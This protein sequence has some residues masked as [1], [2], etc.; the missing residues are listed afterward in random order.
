ME[1][2]KWSLFKLKDEI[3]NGNRI[4]FS[5]PD[6]KDILQ[7]II[8]AYAILKKERIVHSDVHPG[9]ILIGFNNKIRLCDFESLYW[10]NEE[11]EKDDEPLIVPD[12]NVFQQFLAPEFL[13][14]VKNYL[15]C[16][17]A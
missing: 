16:M 3:L 15:I 13:F 4:L 10:Y 8:Q 14:W 11:I 2:A 17:K 5:E 9:N 1:K 7:Q 12:P 6:I